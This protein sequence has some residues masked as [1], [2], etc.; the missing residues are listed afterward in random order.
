MGSA[1]VG[2]AVRQHGW[3]T[4]QLLRVARL[5]ICV[6]TALLLLTILGATQAHRAALKTVGQDTVPSIIAA[7]HIRSA[8]AAMDA[9][10]ADELLQPAT[11]SDLSSQ[12]YETRRVEAAQALIAAAENITYGDA[13]RLPIQSIQVGLGSYERLVQRARDLHQRNDADALGA[14]REATG[15]L[16]TALLPATEALD[17]ANG[18]VLERTYHAEGMRSSS[19][20]VLIVVLC[21]LLVVA[22]AATQMVLS[23]RMHRTLNPFLILATLVVCVL[24][25]FTL[26][27]LS[28]SHEELRIAKE[29]AFTSIHALWRARAAAYGTRSDQ[30][31]L[32]L[33]PAHAAEHDQS[34]A[35]AAAQIAREP[36]T[37]S[38]T[39]LLAAERE[40]HAVDGFTGYLADEFNN[41]T[42]SGERDA[43]WKT[44]VTWHHY[45]AFEPE[46]R[47]L[48]RTGQHR[49]AVDLC[50]GTNP[51]Q[52][53]GSFAAFDAALDQALTINQSAF[54]SAIDEGKAALH[55]LEL[56]AG[57]T[58]AFCV[59]LVFA[60]L[61]P[62][63][64][65]YR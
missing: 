54:G 55:N 21:A 49:A 35:R 60:G 17:Q 15:V 2:V 8:I 27:D 31:R 18:D 56:E 30:S 24:A 65:E 7:Q 16:D 19:L 37:L 10:A 11:S 34:F 45:V 59:F 41:I 57:L 58:I 12:A 64:R 43:A 47:R 53:G 39:Q 61:A 38:P 1:L 50:T 33:D 20:R 63:L 29:D 40:G 51:T 48:E 22:L 6:L 4:L 44:L 26:H 28:Q 23:Q 25:V 52:A 62:R 42:F 36:L 32:L 13:E 9:E 46:L 3:S 14:Y 5:T